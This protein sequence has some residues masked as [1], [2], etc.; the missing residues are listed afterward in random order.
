[1]FRRG[2]TNTWYAIDA[3]FGLVRRS[4]RDETGGQSGDAGGFVLGGSF[5]Y[6]I[7]LRD[8]AYHLA[9]DH[10]VSLDLGAGAYVMNAEGF[11]VGAQASARLS[12]Y[13]LGL[14]LLATHG[15]QHRFSLMLGTSARAAF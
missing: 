3:G 6:R 12:I 10:S 8:P 7:P 2:A 1:M 5:V 11:D 9:V 13:W 14:G 4:D 15:I